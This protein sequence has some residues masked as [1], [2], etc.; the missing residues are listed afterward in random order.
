[1]EIKSAPSSRKKEAVVAKSK[2]AVMA[3]PESPQDA[4]Q[5]V[6]SEPA[7]QGEISALA[8]ELWIQRGCPLGSPE[9]DWFRAKEELRRKKRLAVAQHSINAPLAGAI[10]C[11]GEEDFFRQCSE[12]HAKGANAAASRSR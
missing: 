7:N 9:V 12:S 6:I 11:R 10:K 1:M 5:N 8:Y 3:A 4:T 2:M